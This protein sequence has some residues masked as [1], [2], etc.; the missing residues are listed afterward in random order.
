MN[1]EKA[2]QGIQV[3]LLKYFI[4]KY[5]T[6]TTLKNNVYTVMLIE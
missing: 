5:P 4:I 2:N 1:K 3:R 6:F